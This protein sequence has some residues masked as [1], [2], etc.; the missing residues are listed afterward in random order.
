MGPKVI[1]TTNLTSTSHFCVVGFI[2]VVDQI[3][4]LIFFHIR[5]TKVNKL[6]NLWIT[7]DYSTNIITIATWC[8]RGVHVLCTWCS[9]F[10]DRSVDHFVVQIINRTRYLF[11]YKIDKKK[12]FVYWLNEQIGLRPYFPKFDICWNYI[13]KS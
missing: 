6:H 4:M 12:C 9:C 7:C 10:I 3:S 8:A 11:G 2:R 1:F 13:K 5:S